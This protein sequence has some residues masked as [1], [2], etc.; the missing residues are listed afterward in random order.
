MSNSLFLKISVVM[1]LWSIPFL[2]HSSSHPLFL[3]VAHKEMEECSFP[4]SL[5]FTNSLI[6]HILI[7]NKVLAK[8]KSIRS[9]RVCSFYLQSTHLKRRIEDTGAVRGGC[10]S[11]F[12]SFLI[13]SIFHGSFKIMF[14]LFLS[15]PG[16][17]KT[18]FS[19]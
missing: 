8:G 12:G 19:S 11:H 16:F 5:S 14:N 1:N 10:I 17:F 3:W 6:L 18:H 4:N 13:F 9:Q 15:L 2:R 7:K